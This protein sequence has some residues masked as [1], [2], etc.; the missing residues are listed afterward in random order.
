MSILVTALTL[1]IDLSSA[2]GSLA[3]ERNGQIHEVMVPGQMNHSEELLSS[4]ETLLHTH[5]F[6]LNDI[7][8]ILVT[9]GPGSFTGLRI[10]YATAK[11]LATSLGAEIISYSTSECRHLAYGSSALVVTGISRDK[12]LIEDCQGSQEART[13]TLEEWK[14]ESQEGHGP[15]LIDDNTAKV[16]EKNKTLIE[17]PCRAR[18]LI[19]ARGRAKSEERYQTLSEQNLCSP[20]YYGTTRFK[21]VEP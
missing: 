21:M 5:A 12:Y 10:A 9:K 1:A 19:G 11:A 4:L 14:R 7:Q 2:N 8:T 20:E 3:L 16:S 17:W 18:F 6:S 15:F 13:L